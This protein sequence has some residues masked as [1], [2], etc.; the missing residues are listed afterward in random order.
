[1]EP[2]TLDMQNDE[3]YSKRELDHFF[4][5]LRERFVGTM[6]AIKDT[7]ERV[8]TQTIKTNGRVTEMEKREISR[9]AQMDV[10]KMLLRVLVVSFVAPL[11]VG[12]TLFILNYFFKG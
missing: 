8:E 3:Q 9:D 1:M 4:N 5:D 10:I 6:T 7:V 11:V 12:A 2:S